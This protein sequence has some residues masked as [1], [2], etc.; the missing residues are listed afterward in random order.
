MSKNEYSSLEEFQSQY[1]GVWGPSDEHWL[2]LDFSFHNKEYR[3]HTGTM[4]DSSEKTDEDGVMKQFG[5]Y[6]KVGEEKRKSSGREYELLDEKESLD[7]LLDSTVIE[8][9]PF[10][11]I[12]MDDE[13]VLLGQ[14]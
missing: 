2:G 12:I 10:R 5:L 7:E 8:G 14:D 1:V 11:I 3:L 13:T 4:Y 6:V 9:I